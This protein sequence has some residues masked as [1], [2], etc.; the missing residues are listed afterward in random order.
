M[1]DRLPVNNDVECLRVLA[2]AWDIVDIGAH[3][4]QY[5]KWAAKVSCVCGICDHVYVCMVLYTHT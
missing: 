3:V 5:Y 1:K 2:S 4:V